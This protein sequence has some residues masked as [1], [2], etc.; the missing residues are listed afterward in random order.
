MALWPTVQFSYRLLSSLEVCWC[1]ACQGSLLFETGQESVGC[2]F[3]LVLQVAGVKKTGTSWIFL[4][5]LRRRFEP[6]LHN[7]VGTIQRVCVLVLQ[8]VETR[9]PN[10]TPL[11]RNNGWKLTI[12]SKSGGKRFIG[13]TNCSQLQISDALN[14]PTGDN[15]EPIMI[16]QGIGGV[17][18]QSIVHRFNESR[19]RSPPAWKEQLRMPWK[20]DYDA[21]CKFSFNMTT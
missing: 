16:S 1:L 21:R 11:T 13:S 7:P 3:V 15:C 18:H 2:A 8:A 19:Q 4:E 6:N 5:F 14:D 20:D 12:L 17:G 10:C 9:M